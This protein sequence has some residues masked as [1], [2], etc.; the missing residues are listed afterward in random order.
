[1]TSLALFSMPAAA[2]EQIVVVC[3]IDA[4]GCIE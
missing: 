4:C 3:A 1:M 2:E